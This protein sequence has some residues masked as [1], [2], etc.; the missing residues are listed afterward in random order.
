MEEKEKIL[1]R[2]SDIHFAAFLAA[3]DICLID[4]EAEKS[5][6]NSGKKVFFVFKI[7][8]STLRRLKASYFGGHA[9]VNVQKYVQSLRNLK[10]LLYT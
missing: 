2:S 6:N 3:M 10:S 5:D 4:T 9:T 8:N 7:E 1:Y